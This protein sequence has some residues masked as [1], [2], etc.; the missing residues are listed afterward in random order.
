MRTWV[1]VKPRE[2]ALQ[3]A[4]ET[5]RTIRTRD[6]KLNATRR[7]VETRRKT[8][9]EVTVANPVL[10]FS[11]LADADYPPAQGRARR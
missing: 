7:T 11:E 9:P 1:S 2:K 4:G 6:R 3:A 8:V 10:R 5:L